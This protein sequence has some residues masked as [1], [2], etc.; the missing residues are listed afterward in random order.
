MR[1]D[2]IV[3]SLVVDKCPAFK[4]CVYEAGLPLN[5]HVVV[6]QL[7]NEESPRGSGF[8][9]K[10][11]RSVVINEL[12]NVTTFVIEGS[13]TPD[14]RVVTIHLITHRNR[15]ACELV[16]GPIQMHVHHELVTHLTHLVV[17]DLWTL[18]NPITQMI[19]ITLLEH[20][21]AELPVNQIL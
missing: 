2:E 10:I 15:D 18:K 5:T 9:N 12:T 16:T 4:R 21:I 6:G 13:K 1:T 14:V 11:G 7:P 8:K 19:W 3:E 17:K 20:L